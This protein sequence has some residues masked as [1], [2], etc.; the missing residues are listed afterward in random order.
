MKTLVVLVI[1][2]SMLAGGVA[3]VSSGGP[4]PLSNGKNHR[5]EFKCGLSYCLVDL[6][7]KNKNDCH[8]ICEPC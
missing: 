2:A 1:L 4:A 7:P 6:T 3:L 5:C 8:F